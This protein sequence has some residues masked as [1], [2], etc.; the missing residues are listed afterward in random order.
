MIR[1]RC[2]QQ[3]SMVS[4]VAAKEVERE[5]ERWEAMRWLLSVDLMIF[6]NMWCGSIISDLHQLLLRRCSVT[7]RVLVERSWRE[8]VAMGVSL[9]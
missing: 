5:G 9:C 1:R 4:T 7:V 2:D 3:G 8:R 6:S